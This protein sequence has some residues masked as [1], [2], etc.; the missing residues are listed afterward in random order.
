MQTS[1][2]LTE[3]ALTLN[4][5]LLSTLSTFTFLLCQSLLQTL[6]LIMFPCQ[7][8]SGV[9][10]YILI[11]ENN[12]ISGNSTLPT[13]S[14]G[15]ILKLVTLVHGTQNYTCTSNLTG[16]RAIPN[17]ANA[18]ILSGDP[19]LNSEDYPRSFNQIPQF[20][21]T[22]PQTYVRGLIDVGGIGR[23]DFD[24][25]STANF[26][27]KGFGP[28]QGNV[29]DTVS[30]PWDASVGQE[31]EPATD[32][33]TLTIAADNSTLKQVYCVQTAGGKSTEYCTGK[34]NK[35]AF[36]YAAQCWFYGIPDSGMSRMKQR[37]RK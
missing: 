4:W 9:L 3:W 15:L 34:D 29:T 31:G 28:F 6:A 2:H 21:T 22:Q 12:F 10:Y 33:V 14:K 20:L 1:H 7:T 30:A 35:K 23:L 27:I 19:F 16:Y 18:V 13:P 37:I 26:D 36:G 11:T 24:T 17:G 25:P 32:W 8:V 5:D